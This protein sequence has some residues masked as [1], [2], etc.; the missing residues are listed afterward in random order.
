MKYKHRLTAMLS[1]TLRKVKAMP[2]PIIISSTL[3][4]M[5]SISW[6]LS[7]TLAPPR[8]A[9]KGCSGWHKALA[10]YSSSFLRRNPA[11]R[12]SKPSP[13][14]LEWAR[15]AVPKASLTYTS[16]NFLK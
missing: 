7:L 5:F 10:K 9:R 14:M 4:N 3:S 6:I 1:M 13:I 16:A 8:M 2:P 15:W 12:R 11:A